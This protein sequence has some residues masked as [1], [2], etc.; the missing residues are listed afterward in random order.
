ML[1]EHRHGCD[2]MLYHE[3]RH[4]CDIMDHLYKRR[5][6]SAITY[7]VAMVRA[8]THFLQAKDS[9]NSCNKN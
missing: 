8:L 6:N 4:G 3:H 7:L 5:K 2:I 1:I 9:L